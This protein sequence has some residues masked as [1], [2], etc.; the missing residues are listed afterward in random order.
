MRILVGSLAFLSGLRIWHCHELCCRSQTWLISCVSVGVVWAGG[1][2]S[3]STPSLGTS[4]YHGC[5]PK[6]TKKTPPN[7]NKQT[8]ECKALIVI[9]LGHFS[10]LCLQRTNLRNEAISPSQP[11]SRVLTACY[12]NGRF[13][14]LNVPLL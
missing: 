14:K 2:S 1:Y 13:P 8:K 5:G 7:Q 4:I 10:R 3:D 12:K 6:K 11:T 9:Y